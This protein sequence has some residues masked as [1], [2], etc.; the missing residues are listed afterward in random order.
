MKKTSIDIGRR[1]ATKIIAGVT[2]GLM[3]STSGLVRSAAAAQP[4][5]YPPDYAKVIEDSKKE[6]GVLVYSNVGEMNW[7]PFIEAFNAEYPWI[8]V[9]TLD[10]GTVEVFERFYAEQ[11]SGSN[12]T[13]VVVSH[14]S[15]AWLDFADKG[16]VAPFVSAEDA[17]LPDWSKVAPNVY[18]IS[19]DPYLIAYN[20][21]LLAQE[22][23]PTSIEDIVNLVKKD[24]TRFNQK[25]SSGIPM[26]NATAQNIDAVYM[27]HVGVDKALEQFKVLGPSTAVFRSG[28]QQ[29]EKITSG[30]LLVAY[31]LSGIQVFPLLSDPARA[32]V[33]GY[34]FPKDGTVMLMRHIAMAKTVKNPN[35]ARLFIDYVLSKAG[36]EALAAGGLMPYRDDVVVPEGPNNFTYKKIAD[37]LGDAGMV[38][39]SFDPKTMRPPQDLVDKVTA[40]FVIPK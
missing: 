2:A 6:G 1:Q 24:P 37:M 39:T 14:S 9:Q 34:A 20:K 8:K 36:E 40:A 32:S 16:F 27:E 11:A 33:I 23:W 31:L 29:T 13:D 35:S 5:Y 38:R 19:V 25:L 21:L 10:L 30:E 12:A 7:R 4:S 26:S 17:H 3:L 15:S 18:T 22:E 28:G